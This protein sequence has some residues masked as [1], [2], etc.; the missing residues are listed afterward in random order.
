MSEL[1]YP[2][3]IDT[4]LTHSLGL[5]KYLKLSEN[6]EGKS[7]LIKDRIISLFKLN[8]DKEV[9][10]F[11]NLTINKDHKKFDIPKATVVIYDFS[12]ARK[13]NIAFEGSHYFHQLSIAIKIL[14]KEECKCVY[15]FSYNKSKNKT[16]FY[17]P[18][19][20]IEDDRMGS[21]GYKTFLKTEA[22]LSNLNI[23]FKNLTN[24]PID[25]GF[26]YNP[27][28]NAVS[29]TD[30]A[31]DTAWII[32]KI[33]LF[34]IALESLFSTDKTEIAYKLSLRT[35]SFLYPDDKEKKCRVFTVLKIGY[36]LRSKF[37][38]GSKT[39][40]EKLG[41]KL[42]KGDGKEYS[43]FFDFPSELNS[44]VCDVLN[45]ILIDDV[46]VEIFS[47]RSAEE[48]SKYLDKIVL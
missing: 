26:N 20:S 36:D 27:L 14:K 38:H 7:L 16:V 4:V 6:L 42:N 34:F 25:N 47:K 1:N 28:L 3:P 31:Q 13:E 19:D 23:I 5:L 15:Y 9:C 12:G 48:I 35:A 17:K 24:L 21:L 10:D 37:L 46:L 41:K 30:R 11:L 39:E 22:D 45:K 43:V 29:Y 44:I 33:T 40:L 18:F 32:M 2:N 8:D